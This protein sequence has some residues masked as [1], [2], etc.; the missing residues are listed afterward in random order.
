VGAA[1]LLAPR[2]GARGAAVAQMIALVVSNGLGLYLV[3]RFVRIQPFN[4]HYARLAVPA[5][6]SA[7]VMILVHLGL[8]HGGWAPD[9]V[10]TG[11]GGGLAYT[12]LLL[13]I[14]LAPAERRALARI[15]GRT[16]AA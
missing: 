12:A 13:S 3:W 8:R 4:R 16:P 11:V 14:G 1:F 7:L 10:A 9:L 2:L 6:G 5:A 15:T